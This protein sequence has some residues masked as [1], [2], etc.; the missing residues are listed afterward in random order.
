VYGENGKF[1]WIV[2]GARNEIEVE[3]NKND[4]NVNGSGPYLWVNK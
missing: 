2:Y 1:Y 4:V 3:P